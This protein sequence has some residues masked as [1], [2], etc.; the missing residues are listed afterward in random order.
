[1]DEFLTWTNN[2]KMVCN[3]VK[4]K[5]LVFRK[6]NYNDNIAQI[7]N[8]QQ[9]NELLLL[10]VTFQSNCRYNLHVKSKLSKAN[11]CLF[12]LRSLRKEGMCQ[13]GVDRFFNTVVLPNFTY[14]LSVYGASDS[15]LTA[16]QSFLDRSFK[17]KYISVK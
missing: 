10:G 6:S 3:P 1:M 9:C 13:E 2:N 17:R 11:K 5:E 8:I 14:G 16:I 15:D 4:C 12:I 7:H